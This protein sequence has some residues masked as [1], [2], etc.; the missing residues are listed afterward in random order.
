MEATR[1]FQGG[2]GANDQTLAA[3]SIEEIAKQNVLA[4]LKQ[5]MENNLTER[6]TA[7]EK[8]QGYKDVLAGRALTLFGTPF[9]NANPEGTFS[10]TGVFF[11]KMFFPG[12]TSGLV[13]V[14]GNVIEI[15]QRYTKLR[16]DFNAISNGEANE[17][18]EQ[19]EAKL[20]AA[21][22]ERARSEDGAITT[23]FVLMNK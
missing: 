1:T 17:L 4:R 3:P 20:V 21:E 11:S 22:D 9:K 6:T 15:D 18:L 14:K 19:E 8:G 2:A 5:A 23:R 16:A 12:T 10:K 7:I 13:K